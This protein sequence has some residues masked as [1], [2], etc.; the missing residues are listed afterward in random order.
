MT[1]GYGLF[2][3]L[4]QEHTW[5][6]IFPYELVAGL[7]VGPLFQAPLIALQSKVAPKDIATATATFGFIRNIS[8]AIS[9]VIGGVIFQNQLNKKASQ[10]T[11]ELGSQIAAELSGGSAGANVPFIQAL[12]TAQRNIAQAAWLASLK[13][14]WIMYV[15]FAALG[16][17]ISL[18]IGTQVL[19]KEHS[20]I[21]TGLVAEEAN[22]LAQKEA[23]R[24]S[25]NVGVDGNAEKMAEEV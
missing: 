21:K 5:G 24:K 20:T 3:N 9:V 1:L 10:L 18:G 4:P 17:V 11:A 12:P 8:T 22:R 2:I 19:S 15:A 14:M 6:K 7:G 23:R 25:K 13:D 16:L